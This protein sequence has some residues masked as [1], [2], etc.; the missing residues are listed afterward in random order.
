MSLKDDLDSEVKKIFKEQWTTRK[1]QVVPEPGDLVLGKNDAIE[2]ER[3]TV[4]YADLSGSTALV[5]SREW[6]F[7][8][9]I[10]KTFLHCAG[11]IVNDQ[12]GTITSYDGDRIMAV[13]L[14]TNQ[15]TAAAKCGLKI[16]HAV[17]K[18]INPAL[19][20]QYPNSSYVVKQVVGIDTSE[21]RA[22]RT[23]VR[24]DNDIVWVGCAANYAAKLTE[25]NEAVRTWLT[26]DA[27]NRLHESSRDGGNPPQNMWKK[28]TWKA[29]GDRVIYGST[30]TWGV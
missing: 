25:L 5:D 26:E 29:Q 10:Y 20:T 18:I 14:G 6:G 15:T 4:L 16:N 24:G 3:A 22:A 17:V 28:Y 11:K 7:A 8:A 21:I 27:Y 23:G 12:G 30:W 2:F 13:F 19:K 9:E 1:G